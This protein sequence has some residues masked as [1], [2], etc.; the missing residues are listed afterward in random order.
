MS[1]IIFDG[2]EFAKSAEEQLAKLI[3]QSRRTLRMGS[4]VFVEDDAGL[5]YTNLKKQAA[6]RVGIEFSVEE[7][8]LTTPLP[9]LVDHIRT[10]A[11]RSD[12][13]GM[14][15]QK[16]G[17]AMWQK[18]QGLTGGR[19]DAW[20]QSLTA[21]IDPTKD[22]DCLCRSNLDLVY[23]KRWRI[24][25]ATVRGIL[26][27]LI[28]AS[29]QHQVF[30]QRTDFNLFGISAVVVGRSEIVGLPTAAVLSQYGASVKLYGSDLDYQALAQADLIVSATG[31]THL[32]KPEMVKPGVVIIDVGYPKA[33]V[34]PKVAQVAA[35]F[36]PVPYGV[37]PVTVVSLLE[38]VYQLAGD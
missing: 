23:Q 15:I 8:S 31:Q 18:R 34:D 37:G 35:F 19:F 26:N 14:M 11:S 3:G 9:M 5:H 6:V 2:R 30:G 28:L 21:V 1:G 29:S 4:L 17:K 36:T 33:D 12:F 20:W 16:P 38:N 27:I 22:V 13:Q 7:M 32:I 24:L 10:F 25:P